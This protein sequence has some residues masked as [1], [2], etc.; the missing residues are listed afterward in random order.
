MLWDEGK[1]AAP[2]G[3]QIRAYATN[4]PDSSEHR[5]RRGPVQP[6]V[7]SLS[8]GVYGRWPR[9]SVSPASFPPTLPYS[10][11]PSPPPGLV[12]T[13]PRFPGNMD[14]SDSRTPFPPRFVAVAG[15]YPCSA[16]PSLSRSRKAQRLR[17]WVLSHPGLLLGCSSGRRPD[18]PGSWGSLCARALL[19]DP[20]GASA[21]GHYSASVLPYAFLTTSPYAP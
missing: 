11:R 1:W 18:L 16:P 2:P 10:G 9:S 15:W 20:G 13:V 5:L 12:G 7:R 21:P 17:A 8:A 3:P 19:S 4:A 6:T 14:G